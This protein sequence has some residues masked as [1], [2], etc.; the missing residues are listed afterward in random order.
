MSAVQITPGKQY[1]C[2]ACNSVR[3]IANKL[4][5]ETSKNHQENVKKWELDN[6]PG[7]PATIQH[8]LVTEF[9]CTSDG[10][11]IPF[12]KAFK[13]SIDRA[14]GLADLDSLQESQDWAGS[15]FQ[16]PVLFPGGECWIKE[17]DDIS[18]LNDIMHTFDKAKDKVY[19]VG[20]P[21]DPDEEANLAE[22]VKQLWAPNV[23][24]PK[25]AVNMGSDNAIHKPERFI[26]HRIDPNIELIMTTNATPQYTRHRTSDSIFIE[27]HDKLENGQ[28]C[29]QEEGDAIYAPPGCLH[30]TQTLRGGLLPGTQYLTPECL[31]IT[32]TLLEIDQETCELS[33]GDFQPLLETIHLNLRSNNA[34]HQCEA[35]KLFGTW[36]RKE[37]KLGHSKLKIYVD[38]KDKLRDMG[39]CATCGKTSARH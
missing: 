23:S 7:L 3:S 17:P 20:A 37:K 5:H 19:R 22:V 29:I 38:V 12:A 9:L 24:C 13:S 6:R 36:S 34:L 39:K 2:F 35:M 16:P 30:V 27:T 14:G 4:R 11:L 25:Y 33:D 21:H 28:F 32:S 26:H 10:P 8:E 18:L 15:G 1:K 31:S